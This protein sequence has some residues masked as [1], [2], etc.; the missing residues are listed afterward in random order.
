[1]EPPD[2]ASKRFEH[3]D[4]D[5]AMVLDQRVELPASKDDQPGRR[6]GR[7][8]RRSRTAIEERDLTEEVAP[9]ERR[10]LAAAAI[11]P[12]RAVED[13]EELLAVLALGHEDATCRDVDFVG[14]LPHLLEAPSAK[15]REERHLL[16][17]L[18]LAVHGPSAFAPT[19]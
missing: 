5:L 12:D 14:E 8:S 16:E 2:P 18:E 6:L 1:F 15:P 19:W 3:G 11:D 4:A 7:G 17:Q 9:A 13:Q 10:D